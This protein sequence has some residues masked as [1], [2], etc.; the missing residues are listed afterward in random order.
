MREINPAETIKIQALVEKFRDSII[1][2][3]T[4]S[5]SNLDAN[6][7]IISVHRNYAD[8][9]RFVEYMRK[10]FGELAVISN[11]SFLVSLKRCKFIFKLRKF[12]FFPLNNNCDSLKTFTVGPIV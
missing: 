3:S 8:Y 12:H 4:G 10:E 5:G 11:S 9:T 2:A 6:R 1:F 7:M